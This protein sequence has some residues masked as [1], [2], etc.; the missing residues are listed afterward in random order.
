MNQINS[1]SIDLKEHQILHDPTQ[2]LL[3]QPP[4]HQLLTMNHN[5]TTEAKPTRML[6][7]PNELD[8]TGEQ[9]SLN[10]M[11]GS[12]DH[13]LAAVLPFMEQLRNEMYDK[14]AIRTNSI[15]LRTNSI[16]QRS[17]SIVQ[18]ICSI[19]STCSIGTIDSFSKELLERHLFHSSD[20]TNKELPDLLK[21]GNSFL[22]VDDG[23]GV[24]EPAT[25]ARLSDHLKTNP[26]ALH[27]PT[28]SSMDTGIGGEFNSSGW[29]KSN[30]E[31]VDDYDKLFTSKSMFRS[32]SAV[33]LGDDAPSLLPE[34]TQAAVMTAQRVKISTKSNTRKRTKREQELVFIEGTYTD[35]DV[36]LGRGGLANRHP[37]NQAYLR[38]KEQMQNRYLIASKDDK[39]GI[40]QELV[41]WIYAHGGR[42]LKFDKHENQWYVVDDHTARKKASQ[43]L[44]E[45]NTAENRARKR[46]KYSAK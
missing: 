40:S 28:K 15:G 25:Q 4:K 41:D 35:V 6:M 43:T 10:P 20:S 13:P 37:G 21:S 26:S 17:N 42:F 14:H 1:G 22:N 32:S 36:L 8:N 27:F 39:T 23:L 5:F 12:N 2:N 24:L 38:Q 18:R 30:F 34:P 46:A 16:E 9:Q 44:R 3:F 19:G 31:D 33:L 29:T 11:T 7:E 45:I